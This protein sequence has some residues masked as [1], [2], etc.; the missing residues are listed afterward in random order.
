M[1]EDASRP[2]H[3]PD[4]AVVEARGVVK[5]F[6][7]LEELNAWLGERCKTLWAELRHPEHKAFSVAEMLEHEQGLGA[8]GDAERPP[9]PRPPAPPP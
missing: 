6:G 5:R 1:T 8:P 4:Q 2:E 7:S 9:R 3:I